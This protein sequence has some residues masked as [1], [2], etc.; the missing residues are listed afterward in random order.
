MKKIHIALC[1][2]LF[3]AHQT[4]AS[5]GNLLIT[6]I[7]NTPDNAEFVEIYN[8]GAT[9]ISLD[10]V[11][12][13][14]ATYANGG[15]YYYKIVTGSNYGGGGFSDF[16]AR[17]P[18]GA[19]IAPGEYQTIALAGSAAFTAV[20]GTSPTYELYE[21][22]TTADAIPDMREALPGSI[23]DQGALSGGTNNGE[24]LVLYYWDGASDLVQDIDYALW[25]DKVEAIDKTGVSIDGPDGDTSP[26]TYLADTTI[27]SQAVISPSDPPA[28]LSWQRSNFTEGA[29]SNTGGNGF[30]GHD[31]TSEDLNNTWTT[32]IPSPNAALGTGV[33]FLVINELD[34]LGSADFIELFDG[35]G[36][37]TPLNGLS[38]VLY[39]GDTDS[40]Y[41]VVDLDGYSTDANGYL[42]IGDASLT[43]DI[44][45]ATGSIQ[46]GADAAALYN[47]PAGTFTIGDSL[48]VNDIIDAL[49]Y[50][51]GQ[52]DDA[53]LLTLLNPGQP[54]ADE[55][56]NG[57]AAGESLAR[58]TNGS[59]GQLNTTS[60]TAATPTPG[61]SNSTCP[62][63]NYYANVDASNATVLR[64]TLHETIDD[65][66]RYPYSSSST[67]TW[68][69]LSEADRDPADP[70][71]VWMVYKNNSYTWAGGGTQPYNRE[72]SWPKSYG[73]GG[74]SNGYPYTDAHHLMLSD[75]GYNSDRGNKYF[76][77]C[78]AACTE[79]ST[80]ANHGE[81]GGSGTYPGNSNWFDSDSWEVWSFRKGDIA[82]AM[83]YMDIRYEGGVHG[84]TGYPEPN[85]Q[86]TDNPALIQPVNNGDAYMG[87]LSVLLQW[88]QQDPVDDIERT[89]N[90]VVY[91]FQD[92]RNPFVDH[93]EWVQ[94]VYQNICPDGNDLIFSHGFE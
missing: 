50:D 12:L 6:E 73:F 76:D 32:D 48:L 85:L 26:S 91:S 7:V 38:L 59:G 94:C 17:F 82:R 89:R 30:A 8:N 2:L 9:T 92:N 81:G 42:L 43:P 45:L 77:N 27:A 1:G 87:L 49:V 64:A 63:G 47:R 51:S 3:F 23:N 52:P 83:F 62:L 88:H 36:G 75:V 69:I 5:V 61:V 53:G 54:Q 67:D 16:H 84:I 33:P 19:S 35:G 14:D 20:Y 22:D 11:Y 39:D 31:E 4:R 57:N 86:L 40:V 44:T 46:D 60:F 25:G 13:T 28:G 74:D 24:V 93:P 15:N 68:D 80:T 56:A 70:A 18:A 37:N 55:N 34:A 78:S 79:R 58:C 29:E 10:N 71:K 90:D 72:H 21:D 41:A 65:H 66:T